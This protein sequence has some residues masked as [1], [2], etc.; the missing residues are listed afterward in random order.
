MNNTTK[1][2]LAIVVIVIVIAAVAS[3]AYLSAPIP[4]FGVSQSYTVQEPLSQR[5]SSTQP[6]RIT[7]RMCRLTFKSITPEAAAEQE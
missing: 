6:S 5:H 4:S 1:I 2:A 3:Y 7:Q